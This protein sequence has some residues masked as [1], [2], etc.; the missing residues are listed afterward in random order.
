M[1]LWSKINFQKITLNAKFDFLCFFYQSR[2]IFSPKNPQT[3]RQIFFCEHDYDFF[4]SFVKLKFGKN[5]PFFLNHE[6]FQNKTNLAIY[7][8]F[9]FGICFYVKKLNL[10]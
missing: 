3:T 10:I 6:S 7:K 4:I 5:R 2:I 8:T 9:I 1:L